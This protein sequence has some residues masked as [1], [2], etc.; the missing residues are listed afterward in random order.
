MNAEHFPGASTIIVKNGKIVWIESYGFADVDN[1]VLVQDTTVFLLASMS[2]VFTGT[3]AMQ[4]SEQGLLDLDVDISHYLPW[5]IDVPNYLSDSITMRQLM[6]H[7][8]SINDGA[9]MDSYYGYPDPIIS[10]SDC[11]E[12]YF[13]TSGVDYDAN[14]NFLDEIPGSYYSY[15]N[16][17]TAL[18]GFVTESAT[19]IPFDQFC[20]D[21]IFN[22]LCMEKTAWHFADFDSADVAR[23]YAYQ[24]GNYVAYPHYGFAD[25]PDGQLRSSVMDLGNFMI[26]YLN[27]GAFGASTILSPTSVNQMWSPQIVALEPTQGL[28]WYQEELFHNNGSNM[29]WGHNGGEDGVSTDMYFDPV[30]DLAICVL[31]NGEGDALAICDEL[32]EYGLSLNSNAS[33]LPECLVSNNVLESIKTEDRK[34]VKYFDFTGREINFKPN[35]P[36]I[37]LYSDGSRERIMLIED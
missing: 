20:E 17:G 22:P 26:A 34:A 8:A 37:I 36:L 11:I 7:A 10:L 5:L 18:S 2:K 32:Y 21:N 15:S 28:N 13:S 6:T 3:A 33:L 14:D 16:M 23:P 29:L 1:V 31:T 9:A 24:G 30:N 19:G 4:A 35:F 12:G 27:E 25:Y